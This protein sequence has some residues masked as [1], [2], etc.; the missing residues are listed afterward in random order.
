MSAL[1]KILELNTTSAM[2][3]SE[4]VAPSN[5]G[6]FNVAIV[7]INSAPVADSAIVAGI[8]ITR[9]YISSAPV[10]DSTI[11]LPKRTPPDIKSAACA[12]SDTTL[13]I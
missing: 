8:R 11:A 10:A 1:S 6:I 4:A 3:C 7:L 13:P 2:F 9:A 5:T 12:A